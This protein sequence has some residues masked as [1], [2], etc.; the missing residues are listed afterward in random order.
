MAAF[1]FVPALPTSGGE[2]LTVG[3]PCD[4][5]P[6]LDKGDQRW[7]RVSFGKGTCLVV[8]QEGEAMAGVKDTNIMAARVS[9]EGKP[10]DAGGFP[11]C[12]AK[13]FQAYP[14]VTFDG[15]NFI[16]AWQ[17]YRGGADWDVYAARVT[18]EGRVLDPDGFAVAAGPG[19][20]IYP[21][22]ASD[23]KGATLL[24]WSD[25]RQG[26]QPEVYNLYGTF[27]R[28]GRPAEANGKE[29]G[30]GSASLLLPIV[31]YDGAAF[32]VV[33]NHGVA[34]W[35]PG[36]PYA[37]RVGADGSTQPWKIS[38]FAPHTFTMAADPV[39]GK[40][41]VW[42]NARVEHGGYC[43]LYLAGLVQDPKTGSGV[44]HL[45]TGLQGVYTPRNDMWTAATFDG[46]N[47][48]AVVEQSPT[49]GSDRR[50]GHA[51]VGVELVAARIDPAGGKFLDLGACLVEGSSNDM[52]ATL[53][54]EAFKKAA[55]ESGEKSLK[56]VKAASEPG[57]QL[58]H[59]ALASL[60]GGKSLLVYSRHGGVD[61]YKIHAVLLS[62]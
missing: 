11:V 16:V 47:F 31:A 34:G 35:S 58:R 7:P 5:T 44:R 55:A 29:L 24:V 27:V 19:N 59:P 57:V 2:G 9:P 33:A 53:H 13:G 20:Q 25:V 32:P 23:E 8:W 60:G 61:K 49:L 39:G 42:S 21:T 50:E 10:L 36:Q 15:T 26:F 4:V 62:E 56:G 46:K 17:D 48:V 30:R 3:Q 28:D 54:S 41:L 14:Q 38:G 12:T 18:T 6:G 37:I 40:V 52:R 1:A 45:G 43:M 51:P 22:A